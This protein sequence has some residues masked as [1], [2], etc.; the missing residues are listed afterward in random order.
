MGCRGFAP[1][2]TNFSP[3]PKGGEE[4]LIRFLPA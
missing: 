4:E 2:L 1:A 3:L